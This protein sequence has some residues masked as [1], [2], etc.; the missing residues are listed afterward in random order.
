MATVQDAP[1]WFD[2]QINDWE[3]GSAQLTSPTL[4]VLFDL[5]ALGIGYR[6]ITAV[7]TTDT[8]GFVEVGRGNGG[9]SFLEDLFFLYMT[10]GAPI[11]I[12]FGPRGWYSFSGVTNK[13]AGT[14]SVPN[15]TLT[16]S[17]G[18]GF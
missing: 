3:T 7:F 14:H 2:P 16:W 4:G 18:M 13:W 8:A 5:D 11:P 9:T 10:P 15:G 1:D 17:V 12:A 6:F